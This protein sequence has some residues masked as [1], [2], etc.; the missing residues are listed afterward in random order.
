MA[1]CLRQQARA[2][3]TCADSG[4]DTAV[5]PQGDPTIPPALLGSGRPQD[6]DAILSIL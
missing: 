4:V 1:P 2:G 3:P 6:S 5:V